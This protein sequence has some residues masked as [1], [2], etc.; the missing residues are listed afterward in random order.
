MIS[1]CD[2]PQGGMYEDQK[3][4]VEHQQ[5]KLSPSEKET[6]FINKLDD[7]NLLQQKLNE[8]FES[9]KDEK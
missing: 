1:S 5:P 8:L 6:K 9:K 7:K 2:I 3:E 4:Y